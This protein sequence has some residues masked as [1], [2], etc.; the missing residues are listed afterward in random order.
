M[1]KIQYGKNE[2]NYA[3]MQMIAAPAFFK[4]IIKCVNLGALSDI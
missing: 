1:L 3:K 2:R 4:K